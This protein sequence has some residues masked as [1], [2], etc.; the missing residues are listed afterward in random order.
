M[1]KLSAFVTPSKG[2]DRDEVMNDKSEQHTLNNLIRK[3]TVYC[4]KGK[5]QRQ[6]K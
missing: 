3:L 4:G 1:E 2:I 5:N 6:E